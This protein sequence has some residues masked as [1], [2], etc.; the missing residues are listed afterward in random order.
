MRSK[1]FV[2]NAMLIVACGCIAAA[3]SGGNYAIKDATVEGS[4]HVSSGGP[5][6]SEVR[7]G[8]GLA[9]QSISGGNF[10][11]GGG[12][13]PAPPAPPPPPVTPPA[14]PTELTATASSPMQINL[15]WTDN[16]GNEDGFAI[17]RC[18]KKKNCMN[19]VE[20]GR[21]GSDA[22][23]FQDLGL[24]IGTEFRYRVRA[25]NAAGN[26]DYSNIASAK[27]PRR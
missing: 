15:A 1:R 19:F 17:E 24:R 20:I 16:S 25:F 7:L 3:Q 23:S 2:L 14:R 9:G 8:Q 21:V 6:L 4:A 27:T 11:I 22:N 18:D 26:S 5:F 13:F 12:F 10:A